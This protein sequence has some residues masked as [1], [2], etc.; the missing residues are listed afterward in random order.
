MLLPP[1]LSP[2]W[3]PILSPYFSGAPQLHTSPT[4]PGTTV[5]NTFLPSFLPP[6]SLSSTPLSVSTDLAW[7]SISIPIIMSTYLAVPYPSHPSATFPV[8][9]LHSSASESASSVHESAPAPLPDINTQA[10]TLYGH[11]ITQDA[12]G[13]IWQTALI[14]TYGVIFA[15][16]VYSIFRKG[17]KSRSSI[18]MLCIIISLYAN[19]LALWA[20]NTTVWLQNEHLVL[21]SSP[22]IPLPDRTGLVNNNIARFNI[23]AETLYLFN[24]VVADSVVIWRAWIVY[25]LTLWVMSI[26]CV[27]L[28]IS[29]I[30]GIIEVTCLI[31][32]RYDYQASLPDRGRVCSRA[33]M[34]WVFSF[35]TN[36]TCTLLIGY[37]AWQHRRSMN[38]LNIT[39]QSSK[40]SADKVLSI[41]VESGFIYCLLWLTQIIT[42]INIDRQKPTIY[43]WELFSRMGDQ[44]SGIYPTLIIVIVNLKQTF[45]EVQDASGSVSALQFAEHGQEESDIHVE[46]SAK[47][48]SR[49]GI[50]SP[51]RSKTPPVAEDV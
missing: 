17:L 46:I 8:Y 25:P 49:D 14:S 5:V 37:K 38:S 43:I 18:I 22:N 32:A 23:P 2:S 35:V 42:F 41:L 3:V 20:I 27:M 29:S 16:A 48:G 51:I 11:Y 26:P 31:G 50:G 19:S 15:V 44:I 6:D 4:S 9:T 13:V 40:M 36:A 10:L 47:V 39:K 30:F 33:N 24:M 34:S 1:F 7:N 45:W 12:V 28:L 21:M